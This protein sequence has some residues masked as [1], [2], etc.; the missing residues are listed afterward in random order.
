[1]EWKIDDASAHVGTG[2]VD[3]SPYK[4][5]CCT[6]FGTGPS[7]PTLDKYNVDLLPLELANWLYRLV[8]CR[9][10]SRSLGT[11]AGGALRTQCHCLIEKHLHAFDGNGLESL[12]AN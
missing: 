3:A 5:E 4:S 12:G 2:A 8:Q 9:P 10:E 11:L 6:I 1:M 7:R